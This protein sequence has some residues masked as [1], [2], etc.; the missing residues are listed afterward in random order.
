[1]DSTNHRLIQMVQI[2]GEAGIHDD[3][4]QEILTELQE[5]RKVIKFLK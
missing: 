3:K 2:R 1:M 4:V 5:I